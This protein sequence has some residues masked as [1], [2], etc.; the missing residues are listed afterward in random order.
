MSTLQGICRVLPI[1]AGL[2]SEACQPLSVSDLNDPDRFVWL[3]GFR[4]MT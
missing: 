2:A 4:N 3:R 1:V